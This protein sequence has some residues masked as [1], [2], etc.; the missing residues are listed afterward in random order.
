MEK[1][2]E[3]IYNTSINKQI[4]TK[5]QIVAISEVLISMKKLDKYVSDIEVSKINNWTMGLYN[6]QTKEIK[7]FIN[8][9]YYHLQILEKH[10][11]NNN[12]L[13]DEISKYLFKNAMIMQVIL[14]EIEHANQDRKVKN[15]NNFERDL[16]FYANNSSIDYQY[17]YEYN[18]FERL[19][20]YYSFN[21]IMDLFKIYNNKSVNNA[22]LYEYVN[23]LLNGYYYDF[24]EVLTGP[25]LEY[26]ISSGNYERLNDLKLGIDKN[27]IYNSYD[28]FYRIKYGLPITL[29]EFNTLDL[30]LKK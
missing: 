16:I 20:E 3:L 19:A 5:K 2:M 26:F 24:K 15:E 11:E 4:L 18:P 17:Y 10:Y 23:K 9:L 29:E 25:T 8:S 7:Y 27:K 28:L 12:I 1:I 30:R 21:E 13:N 14:H 6:T 22:L